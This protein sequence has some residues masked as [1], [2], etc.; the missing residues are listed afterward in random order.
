MLYFKYHNTNCFFVRSSSTRQLLAID[1]GWPGTLYEYARGMK[2]IG[3][4]LE[5][6]AWAMVTH[7]HMDHAGLISELMDRGTRCFAFEN[8]L[9]SVGAM[10]TTI[11]KNYKSYKRIKQEKLERIE[12]RESKE[13]LQRIGI[14]AQVIITDYHSPDSVTFIT[15]EGETIVGDL[16]PEGQAMPDDA[17]FLETWELVRKL[18]GRLIYPSHAG[19]FQLKDKS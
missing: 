19:L 11:E 3:C 6:I 8:Q 18:G 5:N 14:Q 1:V 13:V 2:T 17:R 10:E 4:S 12:T 15:D 7:F 16:P 9:Q